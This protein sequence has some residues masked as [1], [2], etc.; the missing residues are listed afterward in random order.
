LSVPVRGP[1]A[2]A[3]QVW[4]ISDWL[5]NYKLLKEHSP[6]WAEAKEENMFLCLI[7]HYMKAFS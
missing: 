3:L 5:S 2:T 1:E 4:W 6:S 7:K